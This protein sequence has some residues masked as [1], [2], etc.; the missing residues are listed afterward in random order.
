MNAD[1]LSYKRAT[2]V[3]LLGLV[4][5]TVLA[6]VLIVYSRLGSD[7]AAFSAAIAMFLGLPVWATLAVV[8][9]QHKLEFFES[10]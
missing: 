6:T 8:F 4:I 3:S 9:Y 10:L 7:P 5:Q 1:Q 2:S